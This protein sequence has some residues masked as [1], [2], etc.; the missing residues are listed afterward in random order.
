MTSTTV[1]RS[2]TRARRLMLSLSTILCSTLAAPAMATSAHVPLDAN[3]VD[4]VDGSF[5]LRLPVAS[6][7]SGQ[8]RLP[9]VIYG[10]LQDNWSRIE[11]QQTVSGS[12][13]TILI[14]QGY[15]VDKFTSADGYAAS[16][17]GT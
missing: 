7:G 4:M 2:R 9:L 12:V 10:P 16:N 13:T 14:V 15:Q 1:E 3:G 11:L 17:Y 5:N 8:G 6:I